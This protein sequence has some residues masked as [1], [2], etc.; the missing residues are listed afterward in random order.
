M[1]KYFIIKI[2]S[3]SFYVNSKFLKVKKMI[4]SVFIHE[5]LFSILQY[6]N[7]KQKFN[8]HLALTQSQQYVLV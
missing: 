3:K 2:K 7:N 5:R 4:F 6:L 8:T 1:T